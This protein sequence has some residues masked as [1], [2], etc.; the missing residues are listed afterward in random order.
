MSNGRPVNESKFSREISN[1]FSRVLK[2]KI[3]ILDKLCY[4]IL[5]ICIEKEINIRQ[6]LDELISLFVSLVIRMESLR[7]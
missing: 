2:I 5:K 4:I 6:N 7:R 1:I 3:Y